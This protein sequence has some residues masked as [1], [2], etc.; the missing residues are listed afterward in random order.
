MKLRARATLLG[1][2]I[3]ERMARLGFTHKTLGEAVGVDPTYISH[4]K[5]GRIKQPSPDVLRK[6]AAALEM[7]L[8]ELAAATVGT[9]VDELR[10]TSPEEDLLLAYYRHATGVERHSILDFA[11]WA[12]RKREEGG[13]GGE[14]SA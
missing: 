3:D 9:T 10:E 12:A 4:L 13:A 1:S 5:T 2:L 11:A 7:P 8:V 14:A 6:L